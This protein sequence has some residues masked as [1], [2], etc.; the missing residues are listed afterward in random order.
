MS[1]KRALGLLII[2][3]LFVSF[4]VFNLFGSDAPEKLVLNDKGFASTRKGPVPFNH[5][6]HAEDY[7]AT[8]D[9]CHHVL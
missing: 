4:P 9:D 3:I 2:I 5:Q 7:G 6:A 1:Q 8:C